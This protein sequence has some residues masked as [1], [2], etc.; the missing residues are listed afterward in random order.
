MPNTPGAALTVR[1]CAGGDAIARSP[2]HCAIA[3]APCMLRAAPVHAAA[4]LP[5]A[6]AA[7]FYCLAISPAGVI[8]VVNNNTSEVVVM[9]ADTLAAVWSKQVCVCVCEC[10]CVNGF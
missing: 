7:S 1:V 8:A 5:H 9:R 10:V 2:L 4:H 3:P 6:Q